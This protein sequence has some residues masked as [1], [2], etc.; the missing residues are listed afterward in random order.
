MTDATLQIVA[1]TD[2]PAVRPRLDQALDPGTAIMFLLLLAGGL[3]Y[4]AYSLYADVDASGARTTTFL[5]FLLL[6]V[7]C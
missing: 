3:L 6:F 2:A 5:P 4:V 1:E 7:L